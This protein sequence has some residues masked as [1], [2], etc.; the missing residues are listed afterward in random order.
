MSRDVAEKPVEVEALATPAGVIL[1]VA[2]LVGCFTQVAAVWASHLEV[3]L[4]ISGL[5]LLIPKVVRMAVRRPAS[6][7]VLPGAVILFVLV[8]IGLVGSGLQAAGRYSPGMVALA[9]A[10]PVILVVAASTLVGR[11]VTQ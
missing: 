9:L 8:H 3:P 11:Y 4:L 7:G 1:S 5:L 6:P 10:L 2:L